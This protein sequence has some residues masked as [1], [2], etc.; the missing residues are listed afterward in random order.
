MRCDEC[1]G[2]LRPVVGVD[3][4]GTIADY[5]M[6]FQLF[7]LRYFNSSPK[8]ARMR[9]WDGEGEFEDFLG[10]TKQQYREAKLAYRQGGNKRWSPI[11]EGAAKFVAAVRSLGVDVWLNTQRPWLRLDNIDPDTRFWLET[12]GIQYEGLLY[13]E[14]KYGLLVERVD[15]ERIIGVVDDLK[16][17][18]LRAN[19]LELPTFQIAR[20]HN[21]HYTARWVRRGS[22]DDAFV[23]LKEG[24][25]QWTLKHA[26]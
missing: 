14:D 7:V 1:Y 2:D 18:L 10:I 23:W 12:H 5:H 16:E 15:P 11:F 9:D 21:E 24:M 25:A 20:H 13:D 3:I 17:L 8:R 19:E 22:L 26:H 6:S 4:D